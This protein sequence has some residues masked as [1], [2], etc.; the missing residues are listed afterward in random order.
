MIMSL[1]VPS[2]FLMACSVIVTRGVERVMP[3]TIPGVVLTG[4]VSAILL[5]IIAGALF[6]WLYVIREAQV[7]PYL[8]S[9]SGLSH[10]ASMGGKAALIWLPL[11]LITT[12]TVPRRWKTNVW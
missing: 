3:E 10:L 12:V 8:G 4:I 9:G 2:L 1:L 5:W 7:S 11:L 6:G